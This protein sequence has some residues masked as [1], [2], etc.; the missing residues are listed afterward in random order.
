MQERK[1][2]TDVQINDRLLWTVLEMPKWWWAA[3]TVAALVLGGGV[4][5]ATVMFTMG[6]GVTGL[7]RPIFWGFMIVNFVFWVG[8]SHAGVMISS[9]LRLCQA[10]WRRPVTRA[11]E[12]LTVC[13]LATAALFPLTTRRWNSYPGHRF[14]VQLAPS[15]ESASLPASNFSSF[16]Q[17]CIA[18]GQKMTVTM[19]NVVA[20]EWLCSPIRI[21]GPSNPIAVILQI[22]IIGT[23]HCGENITKKDYDPR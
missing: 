5:G 14:V 12:V 21:M 19:S 8:I 22:R 1:V 2:L 11:A 3:V 18:L 17:G 15:R 16:Q 13:S 10:E 6:L 4:L 9:I 23:L 20:P 7:S